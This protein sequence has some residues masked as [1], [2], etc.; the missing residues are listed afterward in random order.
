MWQK[1]LVREDAGYIFGVNFFGIKVP[2]IKD[3]SMLENP[4][5]GYYSVKNGR[6]IL[7]N[8]RLK[9]FRVLSFE[10]AMALLIDLPEALSP[11]ELKKLNSIDFKHF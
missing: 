11:F 8:D 10:L 4:V 1:C 3:S 7:V 2:P 5:P 9:D 6:Y